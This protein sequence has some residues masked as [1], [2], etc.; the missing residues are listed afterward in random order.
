MSQDDFPIY[1]FDSCDY[2]VTNW[3]TLL[4]AN[5]QKVE[6]HICSRRLGTLG[7]AVSANVP[8]YLKSDGKW[9]KARNDGVRQPCLGFSIE[10]GV[11]DDQIRIQRKGEITNA[12]WALTIGSPV[13]VSDVT[14]GEITQTPPATYRQVLGYAT[15]ATKFYL[16]GNIYVPGFTLAGTTTTTTTSTTTSSSTVTS[17]SSTIST[18]SSTYSTTSTT[19]T[20]TTSSTTTHSTSTTTTTTAA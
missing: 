14:A 15:A 1:E 11:L 5:M 3:H 10:S 8:L 6:A 7:E 17:T 9:Y 16:E 18:T 4:E 12:A 13:Y 20:S 19:R 2:G